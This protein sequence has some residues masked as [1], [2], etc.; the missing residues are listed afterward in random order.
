[1]ALY[2]PVITFDHL[3]LLLFG[4]ASL[5]SAILAAVLPETLGAPLPES[6]DELVILRKYSKPVCQWWSIADV[7]VNIH[8]INA[9]RDPIP[10]IYT[11]T[12]I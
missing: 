12:I 3:P 7:D 4:S 5:V 10:K 1:M 9:A 11:T 6:F 8:K 2:L